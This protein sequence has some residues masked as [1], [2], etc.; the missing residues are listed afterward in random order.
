L[1]N[2]EATGKI[3]K[4][5]I[6]LSMYDIV[7]KPRMAIK[8]QVQSNFVIEWTNTQ[9]PPKERELEYWTINFNRSLQLQGARAGTLVISHKGGKFKYVLQMRYPAS[10]N[11]AEYE[12][13]LHGL[14]IATALG[15][16]QL[17]V[18]GNSLLIINQ[19]NKE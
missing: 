3:A 18:L 4:W 1:N 17:R 12:A 13:L 16:C 8:A 2:R 19:T 10:N 11:V 14:R 15:I 6:E 5:A 9:T 7:C